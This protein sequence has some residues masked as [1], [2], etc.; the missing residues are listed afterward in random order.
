MQ[1]CPHSVVHTQKSHEREALTHAQTY[2]CTHSRTAVYNHTHGAMQYIHATQVHQMDGIVD[3]KA[4][5][6][7]ITKRK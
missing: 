3:T 5:E 4:A 1:T 6:V 7:N 2:K